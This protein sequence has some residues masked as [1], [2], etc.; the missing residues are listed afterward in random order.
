M[1]DGKCGRLS[2]IE[3]IT[4]DALEILHKPGLGLKLFTVALRRQVYDKD[5]LKPESCHLRVR[6]D[7]TKS[8]RTSEKTLKRDMANFDDWG[9]VSF[10]AAVEQ[11]TGML[12]RL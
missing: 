2:V 3:A 4:R 1:L 8:E 10:E 11:H 12:Y 9:G 5:T 6:S 7:L